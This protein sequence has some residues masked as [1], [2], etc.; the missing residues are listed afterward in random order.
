MFKVLDGKIQGTYN[1]KSFL[2]AWNNEIQKHL[3]SYK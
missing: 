1:V 2:G 3:V